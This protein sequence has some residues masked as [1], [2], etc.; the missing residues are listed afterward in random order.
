MLKVISCAFVLLV[1]GV[2]SIA[3]KLVELG[4]MVYFNRDPRFIEQALDPTREQKVIEGSIWSH[5]NWAMLLVR[6]HKPAEAAAVYKNLIDNIRGKVSDE[7]LIARLRIYSM[8]LRRAQ[9]TDEAANVDREIDRITA[10]RRT[11]R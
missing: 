3:E 8:L 7:R 6:E 1:V 9:Q 10:L 5:H 4:W 11:E 2:A